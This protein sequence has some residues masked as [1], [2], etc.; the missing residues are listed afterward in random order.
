MLKPKA[1]KQAAAKKESMKGQRANNRLSTQDRRAPNRTMVWK[2]LYRL[3]MPGGLLLLTSA[4]LVHAGLFADKQNPFVQFYAYF[5][6]GIGLVLSA[7]FK[8]SRL[9]FAILVVV[10]AERTL[11]WLAPGFLSAKVAKAAFE[12]IALLLPLNL[13]ALTFMRDRGIISPAGKQ[14]IAFIAFQIIAVVIVCVPAQTYAATVLNYPLLD[15]HFFQWSSISQPALLAFIVAAVTMI[16]S[17]IRRYQPVESSLFWALV[18]AFVALQ[19]GRG[20]HLSSVYFATGGLILIIAV[21]ETSYAMAYRD[22]LTQLPSR[23][24]LNEAL[25]KL[26]DSY[27]IG[28]LDV[29]HF[30]KFNDA[31]GHEAGDQA[32]RMVASKLSGIAGGGKAFRYG[33]EEFTVVFPDKSLSEA[34]TYL[35]T[36]RKIIE[37]SLFTVRGKD[38]RRQAKNSKAPR[39]GTREIEVNVTVSI[40]VAARDEEKTAP[41]QVIRMADKALYKAKSKGRNRTIAAKPASEE[42]RIVSIR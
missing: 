10:L 11:G 22:E 16:I 36:M 42:M 31:Y 40:G 19:M 34:F 14:R 27:S 29:D 15:K 13:L 1:K 21:L 3:T 24:S 17:L 6:F 18:A 41:D 20:T 9:F 12:A 37:Q 30:K 7:F 39:N 35:D 32:L 25:L 26:G 5:V 4:L 33:G 23:R 38:R 8:R 28:M 2:V